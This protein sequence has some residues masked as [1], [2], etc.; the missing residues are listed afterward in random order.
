M[1][2][3]ICEQCF[4]SLL[5]AESI[6][7]I[8]RKNDAFLNELASVEEEVLVEVVVNEDEKFVKEPW[9]DPVNNFHVILAFKRKFWKIHS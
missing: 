3:F 6:I 9:E 2:K 5:N 8:C 7:D 1:P 4:T